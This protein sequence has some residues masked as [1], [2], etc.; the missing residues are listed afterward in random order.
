MAS[1]R[2][3]NRG[4]ELKEAYDNLETWRRKSR[5]AKQAAYKTVAKPAAQRVKSERIPGFILP[6]NLTAA[7]VYL[8][9]RILAANQTGVGSATGNLV[10][11]LIDDRTFADVP[12]GPA[13]KSLSGK[14]YN[15]A[16]IIASERTDVAETESESR[17]TGTPYKRHRS[18]NVSGVFGKKNAADTFFAAITEIKGK[19]AYD[20]FAEKVGNRIGF[21][22][23]GL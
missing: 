11:G 14:N 2:D 18:N 1:Y 17:K 21:Y 22:A 10:Q 20:T 23:E 6:F 15:F 3:I 9:T 19:S 7:D 4:P 8:E 13:V 16:K 5:A 12:A